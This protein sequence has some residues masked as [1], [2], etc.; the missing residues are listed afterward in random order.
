MFGWCL[1]VV[2]QERLVYLEPSPLI[3]SKVGPATRVPLKTC[4]EVALAACRAIG[5]SCLCGEEDHGI[6]TDP[7]LALSCRVLA[8]MLGL[9]PAASELFTPIPWVIATEEPVYK[10]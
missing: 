3:R 6:N 1:C 7:W 5:M 8:Q 4:A 10:D 2:L 9:E